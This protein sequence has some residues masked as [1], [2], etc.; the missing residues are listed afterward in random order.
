MSYFV[1]FP[2]AVGSVGSAVASAAVASA[3]TVASTPAAF[4]Q[5]FAVMGGLIVAIGAQNAFILRHAVQRRYLAPVVV[6][7]LLA[8]WLLLA[9][10][11]FGAGEFFTGTP[12]LLEVF[13][14]GGAM[15]LAGYGLRSLRAAWRG[16]GVGLTSD[17]HVR[18]Q[19]L[20]GA[21]LA[22]A[23]VTFLNPH[24]YLDTVVLVGGIGARHH[25]V[26]RMGFAVGAGAAS[27]VWFSA[28]ALGARRFAGTLARPRVWRGIDVVIGTIMLAIAANLVASPMN[29]GV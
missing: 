2:F 10:G 29:A 26:A 9:L 14:F 1:A 5:G 7:C 23:A 3:P 25:D 13:R 15:F 20:R 4:A 18:T 27:L 21:L 22:T 6:F 16:A 19:T 12:L 24:V 11:V 8:D 28:L 17:D